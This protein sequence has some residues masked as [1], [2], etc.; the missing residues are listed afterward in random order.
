[1]VIISL[2]VNL[3][4]VSCVCLLS[5]GIHFMVVWMSVRK[6]EVTRVRGGGSAEVFEDS[7]ASDVAVCVFVDGEFYRTLVASPGML[8]ELV[9]GHL[10]T[11]GVVS[12]PADIA[13][14]M[15]REGRVDVSLG[16]PVD[17]ADFMAGKTRLITTACSASGE[18]RPGS[19]R[20]VQPVED[21]DEALIHSAVAE[22]NRLSVVFRETGGTH[23]ALVYLVGDGVVAFAEDVGRHNALDKVIGRCLLDGVDLGGCLLASSGRLSGEMVLKA[24]AAGI[25][26]V[27][28][29]SA[30]LAS[31]VKV[32]LEAGIRLV[33][34]V[35]GR[36]MN[37]YS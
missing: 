17:I 1:M 28:S 36:R 19:I 24:A 8:E 12:S 11:E 32:A 5:L 21:L 30:P 9:T 14:L 29:V 16:S 6:V 37:V 27:C 26:V 2:D 3:T 23:S 25:P 4:L 22:L 18:I 34:F 35:R 10:F 15:V 20:R 31:G 33:G 7:V 13:E